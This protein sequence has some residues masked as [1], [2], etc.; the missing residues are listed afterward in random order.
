[1][2]LMEPKIEYEMEGMPDEPQSDAV[3]VL[4]GR[5]ELIEVEVPDDD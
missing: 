2:K 4:N 5:G 3:F 1:M